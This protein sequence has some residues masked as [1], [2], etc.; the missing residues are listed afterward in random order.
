M[1]SVQVIKLFVLSG[2]GLV[3]MAMLPKSI[4]MVLNKITVGLGAIFVLCTL[5]LVLRSMT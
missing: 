5:W 1:N 4:R 3:V 2:A